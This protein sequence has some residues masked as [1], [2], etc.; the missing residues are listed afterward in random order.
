MARQPRP[1]T[2]VMCNFRVCNFN[3]R[4][5]IGVDGHTWL[6]PMEQFKVGS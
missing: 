5:P 1:V 2:N 3:L 6:H 4:L